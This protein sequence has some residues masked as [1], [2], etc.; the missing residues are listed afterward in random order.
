ME[1]RYKYA[2]TYDALQRLMSADYSGWS[3]SAW[4]TE[5]NYDLPWIGYDRNGNVTGL[6]RNRQDGSRIDDLSYGIGSSSNRLYTIVENAPGSPSSEAWDAEAAASGSF[7][8]DPNGNLK[9]APDPY[10]FTAIT[11][12][13]QNLPLSLTRSG[14][15]TTYRYDDA[16]QRITKQV[17]G[18]NT[19]VYLREGA[20]TLGVFTVNTAGTPVS[21]YFNVLA[22]EKVVGRQPNTGNRSYYHT[23]LLGSTRA[24]VQGV[25]VVESYDFDPWGVLM[26]GRTLGSGTKEGFTGKEQDTETGLDYFGARYYMPA[27]ARWAAV[28]PLSEKHPE[29]SP[30]NYVLDNPL[31]LFDPDG[32]QV[33]A[34]RH[35]TPLQAQ[36][37]CGAGGDPVACLSA[38]LHPIN[39]AQAAVEELVSQELEG[40]GCGSQSGYGCEVPEFGSVGALLGQVALVLGARFPT[41]TQ[42]LSEVPIGSSRVLGYAA[43]GKAFEKL[44]AAQMEAEGWTV[45]RE[46]TLQTPGGARTRMDIVGTREGAIRCVECKSSA[47]ARLTRGQTAAHPQI[48]TQGATVKGK[49]KPGVPGGTQIPRTPVEVVRKCPPTICT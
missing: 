4:V 19:E 47:S 37:G 23:D 30:Y 49:G 3:G 15:T 27:L 8:Y 2:F 43:Q 48:E 35:L 10:F 45:S 7:T 36:P 12:D 34:S 33:D 42:V 21:W 24:V 40:F 26:P 6:Q 32:R 11:Y 31:A 16:G 9:T 14:T 29:W 22:E 39:Q 18:G 25:T 20:A 41:S 13:P 1:K 38:A 17:G 44:V 5:P 28:D 46:V